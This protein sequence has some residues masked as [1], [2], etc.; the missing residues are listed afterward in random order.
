MRLAKNP[1]GSVEFLSSNSEQ[2]SP[3]PPPKSS[4]SVNSSTGLNT[5]SKVPAGIS[6]ILESLKYIPVKTADTFGNILFNGFDFTISREDRKEKVPVTLADFLPSN[7]TKEQKG[8]DSPRY[9]N[10][11]TG[12]AYGFAVPEECKGQISAENYLRYKSVLLLPGTLVQ[13]IG[14][15]LNVANRVTK[16]MLLMYFFTPAPRENPYSFKERGTEM[17]ADIIRVVATPLFLVGLTFFAFY[18][19]IY[20]KNGAEGYASCERLAY[21]GGYR[22]PIEA[23]WYGATTEEKLQAR[24]LAPCLQPDPKAHFLSNGNPWDVTKT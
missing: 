24:L 3:L 13:A 7:W 11:R 4:S 21:S 17:I 12:N 10:L 6:E 8:N 14:L 23:Y 22:I 1:N 20:P 9:R 5:P 15:M 18:G 2:T 16:I 19:M